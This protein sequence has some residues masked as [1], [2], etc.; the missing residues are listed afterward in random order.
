[1]H[2]L[3]ILIPS[4]IR[5]TDDILKISDVKRIGGAIL[6]DRGFGLTTIKG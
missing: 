6:E 3:L 2:V 5:A 1:M 4:S